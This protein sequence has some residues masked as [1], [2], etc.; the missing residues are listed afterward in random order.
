MAGTGF[1]I[2]DMWTTTSWDEN[3]MGVSGSWRDESLHDAWK[4]G[5]L[6]VTRVKLSVR[7]FEG[8]RAD[9]IF[10][11]TGTDIH[12]WFTQERLISSPWEDVKSTTPNYFSTEG[13]AA[14]GRRFYMSKSHYACTYDRGWLVV[15]ESLV[16]GDCDW[17]KNS[18]EYPSFPLILY[19]RSTIAARWR[20]MFYTG[21]VTVG[22]ADF[23]T[24]HVD[25]E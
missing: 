9:L 5:E 10:N 13:F 15:K 22:R 16:G 25:T 20:V 21:D 12:N 18:T 1:G 11:G 19:S 24:I 14:N 17:E 6:N 23:L 7:D 8:R 4:S 3:T 2:Y